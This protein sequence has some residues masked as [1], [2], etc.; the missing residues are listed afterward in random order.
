MGSGPPPH[1]LRDAAHPV[2]GP[3]YLSPVRPVRRGLAASFV[4]TVC[5]SCAGST[6]APDVPS[7]SAPASGSAPPAA[8]AAPPPEKPRATATLVEG[9][10]ARLPDGTCQWEEKVEFHCPPNARCNPPEPRV[11]ALKA[12]GIGGSRASLRR[13]ASGA[14]EIIETFDMGCPPN[15]RCN[16]P[17]PRVT[18]IPCPDWLR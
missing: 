16:P 4:T 1:P 18:P 11:V 13:K 7:A 8:S 17:A 6:D 12:C 2:P 15:A 14:C 3:C 9:T 10:L 5:L